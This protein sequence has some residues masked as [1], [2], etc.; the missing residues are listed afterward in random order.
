MVEPLTLNLR[1]LARDLNLPQEKVQ[2]V[3]SLL[4]EGLPVPF[5]AR[6]RKDKTENL[7]EE[8]LRQIEEELKY[9]RSLA[10][11]KLTILKTLEVQGKLTPELEQLIRDARSPKRLEDIYLPFKPKRRTLAFAARE[12]GLEPLA[13]EILNG[14]VAPENLDARAAEFINE[15]KKVKN[16]AEAIQGAGHIIAEMF[17]ENLDLIVKTRE[18]VHRYGKLVCERIA[19]PAAV[20]A[21]TATPPEVKDGKPKEA[22]LPQEAD[23]VKSEEL[24]VNSGQ[25]EEE[26]VA[27]PEQPQDETEQPGNTVAGSQEEPQAPTAE[28]VAEQFEQWKE[29]NAEKEGPKVISQNTLKKRKKEEI[30]KKKDEYRVKQQ[31]RFEHQFSEYFNFGSSL[32]NLPPHR[33]L[34]FNRGEHLKVLRVKIENDEEKTLYHVQDICVP[35]EHIHKNFLTGCLKDALHRLVLPFLEREIRRE[36]TEQAETQSVKVFAKNLRS[37][38]L[39]PPLY[40]KR[41]I[42]LD[43]GFK[44]GCKV[45][46]L[47]EFGNV[48]DFET[49]YF[50]GDDGRKEKAVQKIADFIRKYNIN[51]VAI[52]NGTAC[53]ETEAIVANMLASQ[54]SDADVSYTIVNEAGASVYSVS[55]VAKEEFP[56]YDNFLRGAVSIGRRL[57]DPLNELVK[58]EP[59]SLGVGMYQ[60]DLKNKQ[61]QA[62]LDDVVGSC[63]NFVGVDLN[64]ATPSIL[65]YV[66]GLNQVTAKRIYDYRKEHGP[67]RNRHELKNVAGFGEATFTHAA[68]FLKIR[69]GENPLDETRVHPE[70]Y[71][72][73]AQILEKLGFTA[74]D[75][76]N[77]DKVKELAAKIETERV[78]ELAAKF[79][80]ELN[81]GLYTVRD[82]LEDLMR[83][84]RDPRETLPPPV[85]KKGIV[86][87]E[88][89]S[90]GMELSGTILNV[91]DFGAFIDIGL[92][93]AGLIHISQ[94]SDGYIRDAHEKVAVG[95]VVRC[96]VSEID[97]VKKRAA[98]SMLPPGTVKQQPKPERKPF[99]SGE[100][101][102]RRENEPQQRKPP[103]RPRED[104]PAAARPPQTG[105]ASPQAAGTNNSDRPRRADERAPRRDDNRRDDRR[106]GG[107]TEDRNPNREPKTYFAAAKK[108]EPKKLT[109]AQKTGKEVLRGFGELAQFLGQKEE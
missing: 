18:N 60:H 71:D 10:E 62:M 75:L 34:A 15:D 103:H 66:A 20:S 81:A 89:L 76:C 11:R 6:Y 8:I 82:I 96:W 4:D 57:Q 108:D 21:S 37:L 54:F 39:Q 94:M 92:H 40:R 30:R 90:V 36:L 83:P 29:T 101:L 70:S 88:D 52:G 26:P 48:L 56:N 67:Y 28:T 31:E 98:L 25:P 59:A 64:S 91:V 17:S 13:L 87:L 35:Q 5:I 49:V 79:S 63:V 46:P 104:R 47:D 73:A 16:A 61:L 43:P 45:V 105:T 32:R 102:P 84:G 68:G 7:D 86:K 19:Q 74:G 107:R 80:A 12:S 109:E 85:F 51:V 53:R 14:T 44:H 95:D 38:L 23:E 24:T 100:G 22:V 1:F 50:I 9:Q 106:N 42:A 3:V 97:P 33:V 27:E 99:V 69:D 41:V 58:V 72:T 55:N 93:D 78:G 65:K 2:A 77:A